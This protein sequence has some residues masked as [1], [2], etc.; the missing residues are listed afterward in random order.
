MQ[1]YN[2]P[3]YSFETVYPESSTKITFGKGY[4]FASAPSA[5][6]QVGYKLHYESMAYFI[7]PNGSVNRTVEAKINIAALEDFYKEHRLFKKFIFPHPAEGNLTVRF[8]KPL[9]FKQKPGGLGTIEPF[10]IELIL[11]P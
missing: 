2:F 4:E 1:T 10:T 6:D 3:T 7:N 11:Q 8:A 9:V 5:P